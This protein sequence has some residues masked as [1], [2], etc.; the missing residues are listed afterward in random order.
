VRS[1][2]LAVSLFAGYCYAGPSVLNGGTHAATFI[3]PAITAVLGAGHVDSDIFVDRTSDTNVNTVQQ[4]QIVSGT[5]FFSVATSTADNHAVYGVLNE[6]FGGYSTT[7]EFDDY[8]TL[9]S[10][11]ATLSHPYARSNPAPKT[12]PPVATVVS[13]APNSANG[14]TGPGIEFALPAN[15]KGL[16]TSADSWV[17]AEMAGLLAALKFNHPGWTYPDIKAA[18][19]QTA[20][21]WASGYSSSFFGYGAIDWDAANALASTSAL[22]LQPP[23]LLATLANNAQIL[24]T[25]YPFRQTRRAYENVYVVPA[26]YSWPLKNEYTTADIVASGATLVFSSQ[27]SNAVTPSGIANML[28]QPGTYQMIGF[29]TDG[30]GNFSRV[31]AFS[32]VT[33]P[34]ILCL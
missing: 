25:V 13:S 2:W 29:T 11:N 22:Y 7:L 3:A 15:Y 12:P 16:D 9:A 10:A 17:S 8:A 20:A 5:Q 24:V 33:T 26:G 18:L 27:G 6:S 28:A 1:H 30:L 34:A 21:N 19:R 4:F 23:L 14:G 31:E 32:A